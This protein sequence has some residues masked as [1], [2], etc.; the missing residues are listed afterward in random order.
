MLVYSSSWR[1]RVVFATVGILAANLV[2]LPHRSY[3]WNWAADMSRDVFAQMHASLLD[4][5]KSEGD[6]LWLI[7]PPRRVEYAE[8]LG[9]RTLFGR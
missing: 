2:A 8:A 6:Q 9:N 1:W 5:S 7:N 4:L 3:Q